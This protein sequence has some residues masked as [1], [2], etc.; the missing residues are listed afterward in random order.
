MFVRSENVRLFVFQ[1]FEKMCAY[2]DAEFVSIYMGKNL[3]STWLHDLIIV[4]SFDHADKIVGG[5]H[6][7][8]HLVVLHLSVDHLRYGR[9]HIAVARFAVTTERV[10]R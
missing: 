3:L 8:S 5:Q 6:A 4:R 7:L 2:R 9:R 1:D 10:L